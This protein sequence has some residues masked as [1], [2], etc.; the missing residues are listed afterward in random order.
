VDR[1]RIIRKVFTRLIVALPILILVVACRS[2]VDG[3]RNLI[4]IC[5]DAVRADRFYEPGFEDDLTPHLENAQQYTQAMTTA[6][7]TIPSIA[8]VITGLYPPAHGAGRLDGPVAN[9]ASQTPTALDE[10]LETLAEKLNAQGYETQGYVAH[11]WFAFGFGLE[12]GFEKMQRAGEGDL[13]NRLLLKWVSKRKKSRPY[14][15]YL[16]YMEAHDWHKKQKLP[17]MREQ[18]DSLDEETRERLMA[19]VNPEV[20]DKPK[21]PICIKN[22]IY[23]AAVLYLRE[24]IAGLMTGLEEQGELDNTL[25]VLFSDHGEEFRENIAMHKEL[26]EDPRGIYGGG[27]GQAHFEELLRVP[28]VAWRPGVEGAGHDDLV[29][30]VDILPSALDWL[31][32]NPGNEQLPGRVLPSGPGAPAESAGDRIVYASNIAFGPES[33]AIVNERIKAWYW[34]ATD[35]FLFFDRAGGSGEK[36]LPDDDQLVLEFTTLAGD[37]LEMESGHDAKRP[38]LN[39]NQLQELQSI[40]YLQ[41]AEAGDPPDDKE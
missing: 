24:S 6:P 18:L 37:Y 2:E 21:R 1:V 9:L 12:Q 36:R 27:H 19:L 31:D 25:V 5:I 23:A 22:Q 33:V 7:W 8:S 34:P 15:A 28:L 30:L 10:G 29:S 16:H 39:Q 13:I 32:V 41:G 4:L 11:P 20:C 14:F 35:R 40:G 3:R 26:Y 38:E 17:Q